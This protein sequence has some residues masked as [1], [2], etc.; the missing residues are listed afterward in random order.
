MS[1]FRAFAS[2]HC[3]N[4]PRASVRERQGSLRALSSKEFSLSFPRDRE[5]EREANLLEFEYQLR[6][7]GDVASHRCRCFRVY[8]YVYA[9]ASARERTYYSRTVLI[10]LFTV[11]SSCFSACFAWLA[12]RYIR[13]YV[14]WR[15]AFFLKLK[16]SGCV[17]SRRTRGGGYDMPRKHA[18]L[19]ITFA[20]IKYFAGFAC[21]GDWGGTR[22][23][24]IYILIAPSIVLSRCSV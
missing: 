18:I 13:I 9:K 6:L 12:G 16:I 4:K 24:Y 2:N 19:R 3:P 7:K 21:A 5:R 11:C 8:M 14:T 10:F 23:A 20:F 17:L 1:N 22:A 15:T